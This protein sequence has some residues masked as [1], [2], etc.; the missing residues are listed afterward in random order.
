MRAAV[1]AGWDWSCR[2]S[3]VAPIY[4]LGISP[5]MLAEARSLTG[6]GPSAGTYWRLCSGD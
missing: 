5:E 6:A 2:G 1:P 3:G 4:G